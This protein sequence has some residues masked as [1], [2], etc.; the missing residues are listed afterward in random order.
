M[1]RKLQFLRRNAADRKSSGS[2]KKRERNLARNFGNLATGWRN[3]GCVFSLFLSLFPDRRSPVGRR[4]VAKGSFK[5]KQRY[6]IRE[7][8]GGSWCLEICCVVPAKRRSLFPLVSFSLGAD[9]RQILFRSHI[10]GVVALSRFSLVAHNL[11]P[12][13]IFIL[14][15]VA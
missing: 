14:Y 12:T 15:C 10:Y 7:E 11:P 6:V 2:G 9:D 13:C 8:R 5:S 1:L 3:L 4:P